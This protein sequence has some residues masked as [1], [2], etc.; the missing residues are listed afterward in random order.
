MDQAYTEAVAAVVQNVFETMLRTPVQA[1]G[2]PEAP[3]TRSPYD[4]SGII[5]I[6]GALEG[7]LT[8]SF[9]M[10]TAERV[11]SELAQEPMDQTHDDFADALGELVNMVCGGAKARFGIEA[12]NIS[13][14]TVVIGSDHNVCAGKDMDRAVLSFE[15]DLGEFAA[16]L[17]IKKPDTVRCAA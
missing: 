17:A 3:A 13:C 10:Q 12:L 4:V 1:V 8:L 7:S 6:S 11:V 16:E 15:S 2:G 5:G 9:P 14:P